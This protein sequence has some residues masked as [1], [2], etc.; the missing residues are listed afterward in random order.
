MKNFDCETLYN[1]T[2]WKPVKEMWLTDPLLSY[3]S[4]NSR[5]CQVTATYMHTIKEQR[6]YATRF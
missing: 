6:V 1:S 3:D 5:R 4:V 2:T